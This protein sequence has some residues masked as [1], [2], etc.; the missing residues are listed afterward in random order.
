MGLKRRQGAQSAEEAAL[1]LTELLKQN[2]KP[3][4]PRKGI[5]ASPMLTM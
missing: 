1:V 2:E 3:E 5:F 4:D